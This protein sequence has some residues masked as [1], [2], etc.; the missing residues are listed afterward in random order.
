ME[1]K[2]FRGTLVFGGTSLYMILFSRFINNCLTNGSYKSENT[3]SSLGKVFSI[4]GW[5]LTIPTVAI[6]VAETVDVFS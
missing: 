4:I 3:L 2:N 5:S 1:A 6:F